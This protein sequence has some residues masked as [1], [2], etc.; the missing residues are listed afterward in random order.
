MYITRN[1][2]SSDQID[3]IFIFECPLYH[4]AHHHSTGTPIS[5][6]KNTYIYKIYINTLR[7]TKVSTILNFKELLTSKIFLIYLCS[8]NVATVTIRRWHYLNQAKIKKEWSINFRFLVMF[9]CKI[10]STIMVVN[11]NRQFYYLKVFIFN[12]G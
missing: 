12:P 10:P 8:H 7:F 6:E 1:F 4:T 9:P 2:W 3:H 11:P 5:L